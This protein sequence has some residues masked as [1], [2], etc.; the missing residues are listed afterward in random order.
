MISMCW[1]FVH[2][3]SGACMRASAAFVEISDC[4][5]ALSQQLLWK[6]ERGR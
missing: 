6:F 5:I 2:D 4:I 3:S 1:G